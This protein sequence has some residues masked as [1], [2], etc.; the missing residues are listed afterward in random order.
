MR[1]AIFSSCGLTGVQFSWTV[2]KQLTLADSF[3]V[4]E[5]ESAYQSRGIASGGTRCIFVPEH[6]VSQLHPHSTCASIRVEELSPHASGIN[7]YPLHARACVR[8]WKREKSIPG[9][10]CLSEQSVIFLCV[11]LTWMEVQCCL[12]YF[13]Y[14]KSLFCHHYYWMIMI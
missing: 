2:T 9:G 11:V 12:L 6:M 3:L 10:V 13:C 1:C 4:W 14:F 5:D 8:V 7:I